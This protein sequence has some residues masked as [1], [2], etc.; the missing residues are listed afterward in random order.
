MEEER[1]IIR[2]LE[3]LIE[4]EEASAERIHNIEAGVHVT[5]DFLYDLIAVD[6]G[7]LALLSPGKTAVSAKGKLMPATI[8][9]NG[10]GATFVFTEFS[11]PGGTG[12]IVPPSGPITYSSSDLAVGSVDSNGN[13]AAVGVG[14]CTI[15]GSDPASENKVSASDT[16]TVTAAVAVSATGVLTANP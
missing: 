6:Q 11:G 8:H 13:V 15:S 1:Q 10:N 14:T 5:N 12:D 16:L 7:I 2:L 9:M 4:I 3:R